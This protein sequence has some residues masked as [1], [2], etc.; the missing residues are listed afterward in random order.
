[1]SSP[2]IVTNSMNRSIRKL[3]RREKMNENISLEYKN[4]NRLFNKTLYKKQRCI[5]KKCNKTA[6]YNTGLHMKFI[7]E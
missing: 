1:M 6:R 3:S 4:M 7:Q 2:I 5:H